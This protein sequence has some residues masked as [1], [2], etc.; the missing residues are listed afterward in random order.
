MSFLF[1]LPDHGSMTKLELIDSLTTSPGVLLVTYGASTT[2][3]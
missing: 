1:S 3:S 2:K